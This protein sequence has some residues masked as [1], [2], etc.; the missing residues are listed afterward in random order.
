M[1][2]AHI[3]CTDLLDVHLMHKPFIHI[4]MSACLKN[5]K[6]LNFYHDKVI[7]MNLHS[8]YLKLPDAASGIV[9]HFK[10]GAD[11]N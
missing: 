10:L 1:K 8:F 4:F 11:R 6:N 5:F 9:F 2:H 3:S 7:N